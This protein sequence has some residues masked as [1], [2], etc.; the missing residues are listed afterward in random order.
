MVPTRFAMIM[1]LH[2]VAHMATCH[3]AT[4]VKGFFEINIYM[5]QILLL[6]EVL[7]TQNNLT[8]GAYFLARAQTKFHPWVRQAHKIC[9]LSEF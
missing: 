1:F 8:N 2:M 6:L 7:F 4:L 5:V 3:A 9:H